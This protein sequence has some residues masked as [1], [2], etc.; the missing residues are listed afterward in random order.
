MRT[1]KTSSKPIVSTFYNHTTVKIL[2]DAPE[3]MKPTIQNEYLD[4]LMATFLKT[5]AK[6]YSPEALV[7]ADKEKLKRYLDRIIEAKMAVS[8]EEPKGGFYKRGN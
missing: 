5:F 8:G 6:I 2:R 7:D 4:L 3:G 1:Y